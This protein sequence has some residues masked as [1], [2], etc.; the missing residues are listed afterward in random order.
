MIGRAFGLGLAVVLIAAQSAAAAAA[1]A[2]SPP[3][4]SP[5]S[6]VIVFERDTGTVVYA[7]DANAELQVASLTKLM[8]AYVA[9]EREPESAVLT[10]QPY[11][12]TSGE[13][14]ANVPAGT[15]LA[16]P[17]MLRA[18]L[19]PSGNDVAT[20]IAIDVG[21]SVPRFVALMKFWASLLKLGRTGFTTPVGLDTPPGNHSTAFDIA[22]LAN[23]LLRDPLVA[24][25]VDQRSARLADGQIVD[26]RNDLLGRYSWVVGMKTGH[27]LDAGYC[28]VGAARLD[29]V[30]LVSVVLGAPSIAV[31]DADTIALLRY[32]L[33]RYRRAVI[34]SA[35]QVF[36]SLRVA[37]HPHRHVRIVAA[38]PLALVLAR[39]VRLHAAL[40]LPTAL[41]GPLP[42]GAVVGSIMVRED[43][44]VTRRVP[45]VTA[46]AVPA[47]PPVRHVREWI[48]WAGAGGVLAVALLG[49]SLTFMRRRARRSVVVPVPR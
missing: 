15:R 49:C 47:P 16:L 24:A 41:T 46:G 36:A 10:E 33:E 1:A 44:R 26:N 35:T 20:S 17:D 27:T 37:G 39:A 5:A 34:A 45:L 7:R 38:H 25:I 23:V 21:G 4:L 3:G 32:G 9:V 11:A 19:L 6:A 30:H 18:M 12:A 22:R 43:G 42:A 40:R 13:S 29:G 48:V 14:L 28:M 31:R 2:S 8:T